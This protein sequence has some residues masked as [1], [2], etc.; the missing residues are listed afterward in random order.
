MTYIKNNRMLTPAVKKAN[1]E[2]I[3]LL[4]TLVDICVNRAFG[5]VVALR[6]MPGA[7]RAN[8]ASW[9]L[10]VPDSEQ[11]IFPERLGPQF[12]AELLFQKFV[13]ACGAAQEL[14]IS[15]PSQPTK[16]AKDIGKTMIIYAVMIGRKVAKAT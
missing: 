8:F 2:P 9:H 13:S 4:L 7:K 16:K 14:S 6:E 1:T 3:L 15:H 5:Q 11:R 10:N 12:Y